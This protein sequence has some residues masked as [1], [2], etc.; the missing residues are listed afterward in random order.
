[1][2]ENDQVTSTTYT[3]LNQVATETHPD[4]SVT[5]HTYDK[6]GNLVASTRAAG[7]AGAETCE[8]RYDVQGR[9]I[10]ELSAEGGALLTGS[11]S[12]AELDAIWN[13]H[14]IKYQYDAGGNRTSM[15]DQLGNRTVYYFDAASRLA[16]TINADGELSTT[17]YNALDQ[18]VVQTR[19]GTHLS[20][21]LRSSLPGGFLSDSVRATFASLA[22]GAIDACQIQRYDGNGR[23]IWSV[24]GTG[25]AVK[26]DYDASG[27]AVARIAY[28]QVLNASTMASLVSN[29]AAMPVPGAAFVATHYVYDGN[30]RLVFTIDG[31]GS[32][33]ETRYDALGNVVETIRYAKPI[34]TVDAAATDG[35]HLQFNTINGIMYGRFVPVDTSKTYTVRARVRQVSGSGVVYLGV[36]TVDGAGAGLSNVH[37]GSFSY[38]GAINVNLTPEM[39]WQTFEG[40]ISGEYVP[41][42]AAY[43]PHKFFAGSKGASPMMLLNYGSAPGSGANVEIDYLELIDTATGQVLNQ[44]SSMAGGDAA[45]W[46]HP[47]TSNT[48]NV[49]K[50]RGLLD[51]QTAA[52]TR[53]YTRYDNNGRVS[54]SI[55]AE[56]VA[57]QL[58]YDAAGN[59][60]RRTQF[61]TPMASDATAPTTSPDDRTS[62]YV[63][64]SSGR[65]RFFTNA[66]G[67]VTETKY[68]AAGYVGMT[69]EYADQRPVAVPATVATMVDAYGGRTARVNSFTYDK[70]GNV[71]TSTDAMGKTESYTYD[72]RGLKQ[73][74][75]NKLGKVWT[76]VHDAAG[77]LLSEFSPAVTVNNGAAT[78]NADKTW[79][80][81]LGVSTDARLET[82]MTY[83]ALGQLTSRTEA[84][85]R[86]DARTTSY[87]YDGAGRQTK[88]IRQAVQVYDKSLDALA[89][90]GEAARYDVNKGAVTVTVT[91][92]A[93]G[94]AVSSVSQLA[95]DAAT[96]VRSQKSYDKQGNVI[97]EMDALGYIT[98]YERD[99]FGRVVNLVRYG[100][101]CATSITLD[102]LHKYSSELSAV[103]SGTK[104]T[105]STQYDKLDRAVRVMEANVFVYDKHSLS[106]NQ[107]FYAAK[108]TDTVYT[109][110]GEVKAQLVDGSDANGKALTEA[111]G[112]RNYHNVMGQVVATVTNVTK[113]TGYLTTFAYDSAGNLEKMIEYGTAISGWGD[114]VP[115]APSNKAIDREVSYTYWNNNLRKT[116][117][118]ARTYRPDNTT[119]SETLTSSFGYDALGNQTSVTD[120]EGA[121]TYSYYDVAGRVT[122]IAKANPAFAGKAFALTEFKFDAHGNMLLRT[123]YANGT[124]NATETSV[125]AY[126]ADATKDRKTATL[127]DRNGNALD[128]IDAN[129]NKSST[130]YDLFGRVAKQWRTVTDRD[131]VKETLYQVTTYDA[132]GRAISVESPGN[133]VL[134]YRNK[135][136]STI[137]TNVINAFGEVIQRTVLSENG[138]TDLE[139]TDYDGA[140]RAWRTNSGD[141]VHKINLFDAQGRVVRQVRSQS[142]NVDWLKG[143]QDAQTVL[144]YAFDDL[145]RTDVNYDLMG[146][147][148][149]A[150]SFNLPEILHKVSP[151]GVA[152][153]WEKRNATHADGEQLILVAGAD[154][155]DKTVTIMYSEKGSGV[156][157]AVAA[158][159]I[160]T[161]GVYKG[162]NTVGLSAVEFDY[163]VSLTPLNETA[164]EVARGTITPRWGSLRHITLHSVRDKI[165]LDRW[166]NTLAVT[167]ARHANWKTEYAY[168]TSNQVIDKY[169]PNGAGLGAV[170]VRTAYDK[171]GRVIQ[172]IDGKNQSTTYKYNHNGDLEK[173]IQAD[174]YCMAYTVDVFG[175]RRTSEMR[176]GESGTGQYQ[177]AYAYDRMGNQVRSNTAAVAVYQADASVDAMRATLQETAELVNLYTYD[178]LG[179]RIR[180]S[181]TTASKESDTTLHAT[182]TVKYD[183]GGNVISTI[184]VGGG[185]AT[186]FPQLRTGETK[187]M[188]DAFNHKI[189]EREANGQS[190]TFRVNA[191][192]RIEY[193]SRWVTQTEYKYNAA[194]QL[195]KQTTEFGQNLVYSYDEANGQMTRVVDTG[196]DTSK[197]T[198]Y[199]YDR[200]GNRNVEKMVKGGVAYQDQV[201]KYDAQGRMKK[202]TSAVTGADYK[203]AYDYDANGNRERVVTVYTM[204]TKNRTITVENGFDAMNRQTSMNSSVMT[205]VSY[206]ARRFELDDPYS[207]RTEAQSMTYD[208]MGNRATYTRNG[209]Q[210]SYGV[211]IQPERTA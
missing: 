146:R 16:A 72:A 38:A 88:T 63:Y 202:I 41:S 199:D 7:T 162:F 33:S 10:A 40:K 116:E 76:Y 3:K 53:E 120:P 86:S 105:M 109:A 93:L 6:V 98:G 136:R 18:A 5:R 192:G 133:A 147:T 48:L 100:T 189:E 99:T 57:T 165:T 43:D 140:G 102:G 135:A 188:F 62:R 85:G 22:N 19:F 45:G 122:A 148:V 178:E 163:K 79:S 172:N 113:N 96:A 71:L 186:E 1:T 155:S 75:T 127:Y 150:S 139:Y 210:E 26:I 15:T 156:W 67:Y 68:D 170:H 14:A 114:Q 118:L 124:V 39:G 174:G 166:G 125:S 167:D 103:I 50:V 206:G 182:S 58:A 83:N 152:E 21:A 20:R 13:T 193:M 12:L 32:V 52:N 144:D 17:T 173:Q 195:R 179:R 196:R 184:I 31:L 132:A 9:V 154:D 49:A 123:D 25:A 108:T 101:A 203:V 56:G 117:T 111:S 137:V 164:Y 131:G 59:V 190:T 142:E 95:N 11:Q 209:T 91:Y 183:L 66:E 157:Q 78:Q 153:V 121:V 2:S 70:R 207:E 54:L 55:S 145:L 106:A 159:R 128:V 94:Q 29:P 158:E 104:R 82:R 171:M 74:F 180:S 201:M 169:L 61:A 69:L 27:N 23:M 138:H 149:D 112:T 204:L 115:S 64:D 194:G 35:A 141:G 191:Y 130:S 73:T 134:W 119:I 175:Q 60:V 34:N 8:A 185:G 92:N 160:V 200:A 187:S 87:E 177:M 97:L 181:Q 65:L 208:G 44:N 107:Q 36:I 168:N 46:Y 161:K 129:G 110:F 47:A 37:G 89:T 42:P 24:D 211:T 90:D 197:V 151:A 28:T 80:Y 4:G 81:T 126:N 30:N 143:F 51:L 176:L 77:R 84:A 205:P 198:T